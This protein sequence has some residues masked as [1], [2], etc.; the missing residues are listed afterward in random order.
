MEIR[1]E[2]DLEHDRKSLYL[3]LETSFPGSYNPWY[4]KREGNKDSGEPTIS[5]LAIQHSKSSPAPGPKSTDF[6]STLNNSRI[7]EDGAEFLIQFLDAVV[8]RWNRLLGRAE[9]HI[10]ERVS[11]PR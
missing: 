2:A 11:V 8:I 5:C 7:P 1:L 9:R 4:L 3:F 10:R 6:F